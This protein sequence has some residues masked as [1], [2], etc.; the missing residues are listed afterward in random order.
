MFNKIVMAITKLI[1]RTFLFVYLCLS[2]DEIHVSEITL[3]CPNQCIFY[4]MITHLYV[5][6]YNFDNQWSDKN[7]KMCIY[8]HWLG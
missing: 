1:A 6:W 8:N 3:C 2:L 4:K 5:I 7:P